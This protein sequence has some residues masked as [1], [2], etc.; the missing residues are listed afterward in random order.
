MTRSPAF[1]RR[2][3]AAFL[4]RGASPNHLGA[5]LAHLS[6]RTLRDIGFEPDQVRRRARD[7]MVLRHR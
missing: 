7:P 2:L 4:R 6:D 5:D 3:L 1:S